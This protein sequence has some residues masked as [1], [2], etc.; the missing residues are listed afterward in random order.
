MTGGAIAA[1]HNLI[2][3]TSRSA[4]RCSRS[5][6]SQRQER[7]KRRD[8]PRRSPGPPGKEFRRAAPV[9]RARKGHGPGAS[10]LTSSAGLSERELHERSARSRAS[11]S[12]P[13]AWKSAANKVVLEMKYT[14][15]FSSDVHADEGRPRSTGSQGH[16]QR[17]LHEPAASSPS[18]G[19]ASKAK[20]KRPPANGSRATSWAANSATT[21][22][23]SSPVARRASA[24]SRSVL[25]RP[26]DEPTGGPGTP[27]CAVSPCLYPNPTR[28]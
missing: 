15:P 16:D 4:R 25:R 22:A 7:G 17:R 8:R 13:S 10:Q 9:L 26:A 5:S 23:T 1:S 11:R 12:K 2:K 14:A 3:S 21:K 20:R 18:S 27:I 6:G 24:K 28:E 19:P